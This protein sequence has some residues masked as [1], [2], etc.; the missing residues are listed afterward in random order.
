MSCQ[1]EGGGDLLNLLL[2]QNVS[3]LLVNDDKKAHF[4]G[5]IGVGGRNSGLRY[6]NHSDAILQSGREVGL[7]H[8]Y[9]K[10]K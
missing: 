8:T 10:E 1:D 7:S 4:I 3:T 2:N 9:S 6:R 5:G